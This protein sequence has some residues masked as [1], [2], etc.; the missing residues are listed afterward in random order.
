[1]FHELLVWSLFPYLGKTKTGETSQAWVFDRWN[2]CC[3]HLLLDILLEAL[4]LAPNLSLSLLFLC[5]LPYQNQSRLIPS[6]MM[7]GGGFF[8]RL[9]AGKLYT[10]LGYLRQ[11]LKHL[12]SLAMLASLVWLACCLV[13]SGA[14]LPCCRILPLRCALSRLAL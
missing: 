10:D 3:Q 1:M 6:Q 5:L 12:V 11:F 14:L 4:F 7:R 13:R 8:V 2:A 9:F